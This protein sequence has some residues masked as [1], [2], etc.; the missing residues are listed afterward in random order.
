MRLSTISLGLTIILVKF[1]KYSSFIYFNVLIETQVVY[2]GQVNSQ[3]FRRRR[4]IADTTELEES[5]QTLIDLLNLNRRLKRCA[6]NQKGIPNA[7]DNT[8][9]AVQP[10]GYGGYGYGTNN[11]GNSGSYG[12]GSNSGWRTYSRSTDDTGTDY[13]NYKT[14]QNQNQAY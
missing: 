14:S 3:I 11:G 8:G 7:Y 13:G 5:I 2:N 12:S 6:P 9:L 1:S 4:A 10:T